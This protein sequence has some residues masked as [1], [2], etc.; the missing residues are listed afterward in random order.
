MLRRDERSV[1]TIGKITSYEEERYGRD[2][3]RSIMSTYYHK[4]TLF[5][6]F[7]VIVGYFRYFLL[8]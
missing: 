5:V 8:F 1:Y 7:G 3:Q 4:E 6:V 2:E